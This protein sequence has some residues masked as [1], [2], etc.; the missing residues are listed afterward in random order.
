MIEAFVYPV[1]AVLKLWHWLLASVFDVPSSTAWVASVILLVV[2][3]RALISPLT[4]M[5]YKTSRLTVVM[6][7]KL[8]AVKERYGND[9]TPEGVRLHEQ[10]TRRIHKEHSYNPLAGCGPALLQV[11]FF[12]GL[13]R[14]LLWMAVPERA[15]GHTIGVLTP[16]DV[17]SFQ[18]ASFL[19]VPLPA[20]VSMTPEQFDHLGTTLADVRS[21]A[22]PMILSAVV[23]TTFNLVLSQLRT[24]STLEWDNPAVRR[25][26]RIVWYFVPLVPLMIGLAGLTGMVPVALLLYWFMGNLW[27][28]GLTIFL[29][30]LVVKKIPLDDDTRAHIT[31]SRE[32]N[33]A[34]EA[35]LRATKRSRRRRR[36]AALTHP[37]T[38]RTVNR[39]LAAEKADAKR[40]RHEAKA[41][42]KELAR[43]RGKA[44]KEALRRQREEAKQRRA[45][46]QAQKQT[47]ENESGLADNDNSTGT[48]P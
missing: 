12:L 42:K 20:Y 19:G 44:K 15:Q 9:T 18:E 35:E 36:L 48:A 14:L 21:L 5:S 2:T 45:E 16:A 47:Q 37:S 1:S 8:A 7:P 6:R 27:T 43:Q 25:L 28:L 10:E 3:V 41:E 38:L 40:Q 39:E 32:A 29:W 17:A 46:R 34:A 22:I 30:W 24:R 13:Y 31:T 4:W 23:F 11:P 26:Y 33:L